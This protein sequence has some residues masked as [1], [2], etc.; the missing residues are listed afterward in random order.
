MRRQATPVVDER[1]L[2][3]IR[4]L[5][6]DGRMPWSEI[7]S[8][9]EVSEATVYLRVKKLI[10]EGVIKGFTVNVEPSKLGLEASA[11]FLIKARAD[12]L[13]KVRELLRSLNY[14]VEAYETSGPY[15]FLVKVLAPT[16][17][18][19]SAALDGI[20]SAPGVIEV[21]SIMVINELKRV[22]SVASV[23]E[24]WSEKP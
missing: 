9:M 8:K 15:N 1:D 12:S 7:A 2:Q 17:R 10:S 20:A 6:E 4:Y 21:S 5:E 19:L 16:Q 23:Y 24:S 13:G 18:D 14:V 22:S 3:L 11:Y